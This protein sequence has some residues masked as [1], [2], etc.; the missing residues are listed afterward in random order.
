M[1]KNI[2]VRGGINIQR[3]IL[4]VVAKIRSLYFCLKEI[5]FEF[6]LY[7]RSNTYIGINIDI[8]ISRHEL[9]TFDCIARINH[10]CVIHLPSREQSTRQILPVFTGTNSILIPY[11]S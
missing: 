4:T 6:Q 9:I 1:S 8:Y 7:N 2:R 10:D 5:K 3:T 11:D